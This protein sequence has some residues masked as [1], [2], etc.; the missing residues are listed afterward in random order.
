MKRRIGQWLFVVGGILFGVGIGS[1][2]RAIV[3][4]GGALVALGLYVGMVNW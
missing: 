1:G 4:L 3:F 2:S